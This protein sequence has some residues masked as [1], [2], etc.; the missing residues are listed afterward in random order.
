MII[1]NFTSLKY[2]GVVM[3]KWYNKLSKGQ[4]LTILIPAVIAGLTIGADDMGDLKG[5]ILTCMV[6]V[7]PFIYFELE[8][9]K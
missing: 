6:V 3:Q 2:K 9:R 8:K 1:I 4:K 5:I 7:P